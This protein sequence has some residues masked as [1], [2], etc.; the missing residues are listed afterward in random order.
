MHLGSR[1]QATRVTAVGFL[2]VLASCGDDPQP[3]PAAIDLVPITDINPADGVV[4]VNLVAAPGQTRFDA[5]GP[6][7][8]WGYA[9]GARQPL[10]PIVPGPVIEARQGD[11]VIVH[12]TNLLPEGTTVHW[13]GIR[14]P[15]GADGTH[16]TQHEVPPGGTF[17]YTFVAVDAGTFWYHPHMHA[18][19]QIERGLAGALIVRGGIE[20]P[21]DADRLFVLDDVK[22]ETNGQ[23]SEVT[24]ATDLM[25]GRQGNLL[26]A[27]GRSGGQIEVKNGARERWRLVNAANGRYF[28]LR[29]PARSLTVI[30]W[31]GGLLAQPYAADS[32]L[33][34][35]GER[36]EVLVELSGAPGEVIPVETIYYFRA[37][38]LPFADPEPVF[39]VK[40]GAESASPGPMPA[41]SAPFRDIPVDATTPLRSLVL[42]EREPVSDGEEP[43]FFINGASFPN[44]PPVAATSGAVEIWTFH[45]MAEMDHPMHLHGMF[46]QVL[47][48]EGAPPLA[49]GLKDTV[50]V[51][52]HGEVRVAVR[53][54]GPGRWMYHCHILEHVERGMM[55]ELVLSEAP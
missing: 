42:E 40:I 20:V 23:L 46:F 26:L 11:T 16:A 33:V 6:A 5:D 35:P 39:T 17:D 28:N 13:H 41:V 2:G 48:M 8:I 51:K 10:T 44:V 47:E 22:L 53:F 14:V 3:K 9:D 49:R 25:L 1:G 18:D 31:D 37:H 15:N 50:N 43:A 12:F 29:L 52:S 24:D 34:A 7:N 32:I 36:Y 38:G 30:G 4:E 54:G 27:N 21:V 55:G 19:V 45:N